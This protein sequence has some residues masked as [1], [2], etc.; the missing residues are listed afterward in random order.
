MCFSG[1]TA[2]MMQ[3]TAVISRPNTVA[4][5]SC[6]PAS[7]QIERVHLPL[8][9]QVVMQHAPFWYNLNTGGVGDYL[10]GALLEGVCLRVGD[11]RA[12]S[13]QEKKTMDQHQHHLQVGDS[14]HTQ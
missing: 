5:Y 2:P 10:A 6:P 13:A 14:V 11:Q 8:G 7:H 1:K 4:L 9:K 12:A 3:A